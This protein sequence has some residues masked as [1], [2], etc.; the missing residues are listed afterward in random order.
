[1]AA[2][3]RRFT[4]RRDHVASP[5]SPA[6][7]LHRFAVF[8]ACLAAGVCNGQAVVAGASTPDAADVAV[9]PRTHA[10]FVAGDSNNVVYVIDATT[11]AVRTV[12]TGRGPQ[13][14]AINAT[15]N[16]IYVSNELDAS[17]SIIDGG[18]LA[19]TTLPI[20]GAGPI[21]VDEAA[22]R[23]YVMRRGNNG[24]VTVMDGA[25][26]WYYAIDT[27]SYVPQY[28]ALDAAVHRL[29]V[30]HSVSGDVRSIDLTSASDHPPTVSIQVAGQP[31]Y[32]ALDAG[33][34][35]LYVES[36]DAREPLVAID[37]QL[38]IPRFQALYGRASKPDPK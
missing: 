9:N 18:T 34:H 19:G 10:I 2:T 28:M 29:F 36:D 24:E 37:T 1:M 35:R 17:L 6:A 32:L 11:F 14:L 21:V 33:A 15:A 5:T 26:A 3:F 23:A 7:M 22:N 12:P 4:R 8:L 13:Y 25:G 16:R 31:G 30:S 20:G 27:G 38:N